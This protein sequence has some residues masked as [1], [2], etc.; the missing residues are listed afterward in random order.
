MSHF[1]NLH[2]LSGCKSCSSFLGWERNKP[3][4]TISL[5]QGLE[6]NERTFT[7]IVNGYC[8]EGQIKEALRFLYW[9]LS[10]IFLCLMS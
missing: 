10:L 8:K 2:P 9:G 7:V 5:P 3:H 4:S 1:T 6:P